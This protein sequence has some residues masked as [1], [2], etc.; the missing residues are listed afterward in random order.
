MIVVVQM[1][2]PRGPGALLA[3]VTG[4]AGS[5]VMNKR[6]PAYGAAAPD[7]VQAAQCIMASRNMQFWARA[8]TLASYY[9]RN[10]ACVFART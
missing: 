9:R 4:Q 5:H 1:S 7:L 6:G 8:K 3:P 10:S 2:Q